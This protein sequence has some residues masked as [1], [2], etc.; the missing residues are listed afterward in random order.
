[1]SKYGK[2]LQPTDIYVNYADQK[3]DASELNEKLKMD[4]EFGGDDEDDDIC[5][6][7]NFKRMN[8]NEQSRN[9]EQKTR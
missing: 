9:S 5:K 1:M 6:G 7:A 8:L 4:I 3:M 2:G